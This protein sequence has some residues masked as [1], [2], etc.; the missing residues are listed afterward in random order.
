LLAQ[1]NSFDE[2]MPVWW[3]SR[4]ALAAAPGEYY[5]ASVRKRTDAAMFPAQAPCSGAVKSLLFI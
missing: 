4:V 1:Q 5:L 2:R 3:G